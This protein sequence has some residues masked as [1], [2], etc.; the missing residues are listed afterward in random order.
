MLMLEQRTIRTLLSLLLPLLLVS[1][2]A[3][4]AGAAELRPPI[5][6][7]PPTLTP[8][9]ADYRTEWKLGWFSIDIDAKRS[10]QRLANGNWFLSFE[11]ETGAAALKETSE[12][13]L[14]DGQIQPLEYHYDAS[15]LFNEPDRSLLFLPPLRLV[16]DLKNNKNYPEAWQQEIQ[17]NLTYMLQ[18][19][20]DLAAGKTELAY[21]VFEKKR[22]KEFRFR[23][24][25]EEVINTRIGKLRTLKIEQIRDRKSREVFAWFAIDHHYNLVQLRDKENGKTRYQIDIT[26]LS[27]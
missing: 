18:A 22:A 17:D 7:A 11:A 15:G 9:S 12:F 21:T 5:N 25:G 16:K 24:V 14:K 2:P 10:L 6:S 3:I 23:V 8:F 20:L 4:A 27:E 13:S 26:H 19:G 1:T